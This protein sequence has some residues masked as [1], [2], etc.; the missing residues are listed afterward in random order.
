[1]LLSIA[2]NHYFLDYTIF[3]L[4]LIFESFNES[5]LYFWLPNQ[6]PI[7]ILGI[8]L[9]YI[10]KNIVL[11]FNVGQRILVGSI[12]LYFGFSFFEFSLEYPFYF[13]KREYLYGIIFVFFAIGIYT[14]NNKFIINDFVQKIGVVSFSM[15]LNHFL[16]IFLLSYVL[17]GVCKK[18]LN[19]F[20]SLDIILQN[21]IV[22]GCFY[23]L[24]VMMTY[25]ISKFTY[26]YVEVKGIALGDKMTKEFR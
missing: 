14:T 9:Y 11:S 3:L 15:Y 4:N 23:F 25:S 7:F 5:S 20:I 12:F 1:M 17:K 18:Y 19:S 2:I 24:I 10:N 16:I 21:N 6:L 22:F 26:S 8:I 13:I